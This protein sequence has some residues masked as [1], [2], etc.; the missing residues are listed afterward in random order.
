M[1]QKKLYLI[2]STDELSRISIKEHPGNILKL[3]ADVH[4]LKCYQVKRFLNNLINII[5]VSFELI[6]I[7]GFNHG[8]AIRDMLSDNFNN[9]HLVRKYVS[10]FNQG[11]THMIIAA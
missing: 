9:L 8:T 1:I 11:V 5:K 2:F 7:H 6:V 10:Q 4:G 3:Y